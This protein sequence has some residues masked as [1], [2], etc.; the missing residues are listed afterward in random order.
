MALTLIRD[1]KRSYIFSSL[2]RKK[3]RHPRLEDLDSIEKASILIDGT[4]ILKIDN[5]SRLLKWIKNNKLKIKNEY[6]FDGATAYP[7]FIESHTHLVFDGNRA[8]EFELRNQ[9]VSYQKIAAAGGGI[10]STMAATREAKKSDLL[11][12]AQARVN[13]FAAQGVG[14]IESKTGYALNKKDELKCLEVMRELKGPMIKATFLGAHALPPEFK[15]N[16]DGYLAEM[17]VLALKV[18]KL[19]LAQR[20][21]IFIEDGF[22]DL[23]KGREYLT[24]L[25]KM[26]FD[27]CIHA[28]QLSEIGA[29]RLGVEFNA[30]SV[31]H[32]VHLGESDLELLAKS[33]T[34]AVLLPAA[35]FYLKCGYPPARKLLDAGGRLALATD[36][37]PGSSPTQDLSFVGLLART[38]MK[39]TS[40]E[41]WA[42]YTVGASYALGIQDDYGSLEPGKVA[43][44]IISYADLEE[45]FYSVGHSPVD[46]FF[47][48]GSRVK[49]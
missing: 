44:L 11:L 4:K 20:A 25:A 47:L 43:S 33:E 37:N 49:I 35:D 27:L 19:G 16:V 36:F 41:V 24:E 32:V 45:F 40:A 30:R 10:L 38:E 3:A 14:V 46:S 2:A 23:Q 42:A 22:F 48:N 5:Q 28:D 13:R 8:Q 17:L 12:K 34:T 21:D 7:S 39:M 15:G 9:G 18:K 1:L 26:G 6:S 29:S 31:D